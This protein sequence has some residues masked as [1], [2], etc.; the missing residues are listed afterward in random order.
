[1]LVNVGPRHSDTPVRPEDEFRSRCRA[2]AS[3]ALSARK[4]PDPGQL[5][6]LSRVS[7]ALARK[8]VPLRAVLHTM[9]V[10]AA[11]VLR[12]KASTGDASVVDGAVLMVSVLEAVGTAVSGVYLDSCGSSTGERD[13]T[14]RLTESLLAGDGE[15]V[16]LAARAGVAIAA[17]YDVV[18]LSFDDDRTGPG[19]EVVAQNVLDRIEDDVARFEPDGTLISLGGRGGVV[20]RPGGAQG[21]V[22]SL[23]G[24]VESLLGRRVLAATASARTNDV[25]STATHCRELVS[26]ARGLNYRSGVYRTADMALEFQLTRPGPGRARMRAL[27]DPLSASPELVHTLQTFISTEANRRASAKALFV[28]PNTVDYRLKRIETLTGVDPLSPVGLMALHAALVVDALERA[29]NL[30]V[31]PPTGE[32]AEAS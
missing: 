4:L 17:D 24:R 8:G 1:M 30:D 31:P 18:S 23:V 5:D 3:S 21:S 10:A 2:V 9:H 29:E 6:E 25:P 28:H 19:G 12:E 11:Q 14:R 27:I 22:E 15:S 7:R 26:L 32:V 20:L 13:R 16:R